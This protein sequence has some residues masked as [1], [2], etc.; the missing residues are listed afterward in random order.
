MRDYLVIDLEATCD[1]GGLVPRH[2]ME[3]IEIGAVLVDGAT[4]QPV[5]EFQTFIRP[6]RHP[7]LTPFC[8]QLTSI[9][10][11]QVDAAPGFVEAIAALE[12]FM[13]KHMRG[14][15]PPLFC[16]W[17]NYDK[18][19]FGSDAQHHGVRLPF[20]RDHLNL[21]QAFSDAMGTRK[22]FGMARA[23]R[24]VGIAL[25]G[26]HHRGIDDAR[27]IAKLLPFTVQSQPLP[28]PPEGWR[29]AG[30]HRPDRTARARDQR[31]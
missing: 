28:P 16:S 4:L 24:R 11:A 20:G 5:D 23:L 2:E 21:K 19:Q 10:Q 25:E 1:N 12:R 14:G 9:S 17:G 30:K 13:V 31:E 3:I 22:R 15:P 7:I 29:R 18:G 27:N 26:T 6:V 8:L